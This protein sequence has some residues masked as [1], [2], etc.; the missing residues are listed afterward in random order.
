MI[1]FEHKGD[2]KKTLTFLE[3]VTRVSID[4]VLHRYGREG[5][6]ALSQATPVNTGQ[7]A[8]SWNY[9][10]ENVNGSYSIYWTNS[11]TT[12]GV[13]IVILLQYGH[14]TRGGGYVQGRDF[15]NPAI[16]PIFDNIAD[17]VWREVT[18][19]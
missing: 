14:G 8:G 9:E 17:K 3:R 15:I 19:L 5:V 1:S 18:K 12:S 13:P 2:F 7:T 11:N 16:K 4:S 10:I 6:N